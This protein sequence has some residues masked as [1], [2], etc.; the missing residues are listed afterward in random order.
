MNGPVLPP[1]L[2][3]LAELT[4]RCPLKCFYCS[5]PL[6]LER[7]HSELDTNEWRRVLTEAAA[8]GI[9]QVH[10]S[11]GEP[12]ARDD[13]AELVRHAADL[14]LYTNV[15]TAGVLL[16]DTAMAALSAARVDHIQLSFQDSRAASADYIGGYAGGHDR[17]LAAAQRITAAG[18]PLTLNFV[19]HRLNAERVA[20]MIDMGESLGAARV[21]IAHAQYH[22]WALRNRRGLLPSRAQLDAVTQV[23]EKAR[24]RLK[25]KLVIDYVMPDYYASRP[26]AC[27]GGWGRRF[28]NISP[29]GKALP[30]HAAETLP[31][32]DFPSVREHSLAEIWRQ[33][34]AFQKFRGTQW[35]PEPCRSC[36]RRE[37]DWGGCRCQAMALLGDSSATDPVCTKSSDHYVVEEALA[38]LSAD[39][40]LSARVMAPA[41]KSSRQRADTRAP[42][43]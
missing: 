39:T 28:I 34:P 32:L 29:S 9:L 2:A 17:K 8:L 35:M 4:H 22:G 3:L 33:S 13:L 21:E 37:L 1:P 15:I 41:G 16:S 12:M 30:C 11:G 42:G 38:E 26:K 18:L 24:E 36:E 23:V 14:K 19:V 31:G 40:E 43:R 7:R 6:A 5:N 25:G 27:M 10:F 20:E